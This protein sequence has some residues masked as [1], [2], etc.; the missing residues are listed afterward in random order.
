MA[1]LTR[2]QLE[3][4]LAALHRASLELVQ[5]ISLESLLQRIATI[6]CEQSGAQYAAVGVLGATG[7][8]EQFIP[9]GMSPA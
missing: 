2:E 4:R 1:T 5:D 7:E 8:L 3:N 6:A 9:I